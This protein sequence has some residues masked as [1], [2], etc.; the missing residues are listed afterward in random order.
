MGIILN[1]IWVF[2]ITHR[3]TLIPSDGRLH[4]IWDQFDFVKLLSP[5][6]GHISLRAWLELEKRLCGRCHLPTEPFA[7]PCVSDHI[8]LLTVGQLMSSFT[9]MQHQWGL[10]SSDSTCW[11]QTQ[12][13]LLLA[14]KFIQK[15]PGFHL[16]TFVHH[17]DNIHPSSTLKLYLHDSRKN[18]YCS[19]FDFQIS[20]RPVLSWLEIRKFIFLAN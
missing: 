7:A 16:L 1:M 8:C 2:K 17:Q 19:T 12:V 9:H 20:R 11:P 15:S 14:V 3:M 6:F 18:K 10:R 13:V 5:T 4:Y